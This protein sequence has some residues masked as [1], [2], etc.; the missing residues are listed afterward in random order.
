MPTQLGREFSIEWRG[1]PPHM[2]PADIPVWYRFLEKWGTE[3]KALYYD[4]YLG[5]P[6]LT[7]DQEKDPMWRMW[8]AN[9]AKRA[10]AIAELED[11]IWIIEVSTAPEMRSLGQLITYS[12]LWLEDPKIDKLERLVLVCQHLD[13]DVTAA[14][15][16]FGV[17]VYVLPLT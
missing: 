14:A 5:G 9:T 10:D 4:V 16:K 8:R 15:G 3:F 6:W 7:P 17:Q 1:D 12:S 11:E 13:K 2:L